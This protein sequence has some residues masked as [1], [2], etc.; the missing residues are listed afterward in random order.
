ML[1]P[2]FLPVGGVALRVREPGNGRSTSEVVVVVEEVPAFTVFRRGEEIVL[3]VLG[4]PTGGDGNNLVELEGLLALGS[5]DLD[6]L[7]GDGWTIVST[8]LITHFLVVEGEAFELVLLGRILGEVVS[9]ILLGRLLPLF[10]EDLL[11]GFGGHVDLVG[12]CGDVLIGDFHVIDYN[13]SSLADSY[14]QIKYIAYLT[15]ESSIKYY[16]TFR[17]STM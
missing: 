17:L 14:S 16:L 15:V 9:G 13:L 12:E 6:L 2:R 8:R 7:D 3:E 4:V 11:G 1:Q 5:G 10:V